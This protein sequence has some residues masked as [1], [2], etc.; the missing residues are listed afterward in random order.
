MRCQVL[1]STMNL[2]NYKKM[3]SNMNVSGSCIIVNQVEN[4]KDF[5]ISSDSQVVI[6]N[7]VEKGLSKSRNKA[8]LASE[9][10][11][12]IIAD[13]DMTYID[14]YEEIILNAHREHKDADIIVF[15][16][17]SAPSAVRKRKPIKKGYLNYITSLKVQSVQMTF[18]RKNIEKAGITFDE[19]FGAGSEIY[20]GEE[21]IFL[22]DCLKKGIKIYSIPIKIAYL[23]DSKSSWFRG[24]NEKYFFAKGACFYRMTKKLFW[25]LIIQF[26]IRKYK[27]YKNN[28]GFINVLKTMIEGANYCRRR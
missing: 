13:D 22:Y 18:K 16:V 24:Y 20:M 9:A 14:G 26:A 4:E 11:I 3:I 10:D 15:F 2:K 21:N 12:C 6:K 25:I 23:N 8:I 28:L 7:Y 17:E 1:I 27:F 5:I 19:K